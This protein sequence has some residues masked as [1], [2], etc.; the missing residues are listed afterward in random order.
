MQL[1]YNTPRCE[2]VGM[3]LWDN[4]IVLLINKSTMEIWNHN[5]ILL[6]SILSPQT[7]IYSYHSDY[8]PY[9]PHH[10]QTTNRFDRLRTLMAF[11]PVSLITMS[12]SLPRMPPALQII[13]F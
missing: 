11:M 13:S 2:R 7:V 12:M 8:K 6:S 10:V 9:H 5:V 3:C 4:P 1:W